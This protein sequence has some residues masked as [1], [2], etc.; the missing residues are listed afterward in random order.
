MLLTLFASAFDRFT[1]RKV[2]NFL[3]SDGKILCMF[4]LIGSMLAVFAGIN[5]GELDIFTKDITSHSNV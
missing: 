3:F 5:T 2:L 1:I 4:L